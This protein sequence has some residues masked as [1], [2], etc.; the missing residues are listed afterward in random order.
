MNQMPVLR[1]DP[2]VTFTVSTQ[3]KEQLKWLIGIGMMKPGDM[4]PSAGALADL[5]G[6]NRNTV[7]LVYNQLKD[8]GLVSMHKGRGTTVLDNAQVEELRTSRTLMH[9][10]AERTIEEARALNLP[11]AEFF[12]ASLAYTM[13][14]EPVL[15]DGL[16]ILLVE[17]REHDHPFYRKAIED[18]TKAS[19][20][21]VFLEDLRSSEAAISEALEYSSVMVTTLNHDAEVKQ[22][23]AKY[24]KKTFVIGASAEASLLLEIALLAPGSDI[25][26]VCLGKAGAQ[27]MA[28]RVQ[29]AG[30]DGIIARTASLDNREDLLRQLNTSERIYASD[31]AYDEV[32]AL[33]P[34]KVKRFPMKLERSSE[35]LLMDLAGQ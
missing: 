19:V 13:L 5:L 31:A 3:V 24:D 33:S 6:V 16:R 8:E 15:S 10:L 18:I 25:S 7:N 20:K 11:V 17:C 14:R 34:G 23:F 32:E 1:I 12:A 28:R 2:H 30:I 29:E 26:F 35:R 9:T 4:L 27:W 22:L 21:T